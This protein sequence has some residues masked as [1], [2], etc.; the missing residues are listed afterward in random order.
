MGQSDRLELKKQDTILAAKTKFKYDQSSKIELIEQELIAATT[1]FY[2]KLKNTRLTLRSIV[3]YTLF[4]LHE[5]RHIVAK[6]PSFKKYVS[7]TTDSFRQRSK[8][9]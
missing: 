6:N 2:S 7:E 5:L 3:P 1:N 9:K 8:A 4:K